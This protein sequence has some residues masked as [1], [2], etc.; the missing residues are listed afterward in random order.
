VIINK[1][2]SGAVVRSA[3]PC[4]LSLS[5]YQKTLPALLSCTTTSVVGWLSADEKSTRSHLDCVIP[6]AGEYN[7]FPV[8]KHVHSHSD[9]VTFSAICAKFKLPFFAI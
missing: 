1:S 8:S 9:S 6:G 7:L 3:P 2:H 5:P 4:S